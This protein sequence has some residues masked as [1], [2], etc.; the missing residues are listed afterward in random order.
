M[1]GT[2]Y[3][4]LCKRYGVAFVEP[5][6][7]ALKIALAT[8]LLQ[9]DSSVAAEV[10]LTQA[11]CMAESELDSLI[12]TLMPMTKDQRCP[13]HAIHLYAHVKG[14][15]QENARY[16]WSAERAAEHIH[17]HWKQRYKKPE[18][19]A[20]AFFH[21]QRTVAELQAERDA[22]RGELLQDLI[23]RFSDDHVAMSILVAICWQHARLMR[24]LDSGDLSQIIESRSR[25]SELLELEHHFVSEFLYLFAPVEKVWERIDP[26]CRTLADPSDRKK[27]NKFLKYFKK[28]KVFKSRN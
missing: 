23:I 22:A 17:R 8:K 12:Q 2:P 9:K 1:P 6:T 14:T 28:H 4:A 25:L 10:L 7:I 21:I 15:M 27:I 26:L 18:S 3:E 16:K 20:N 19:L 5:P 24:G 11:P 13:E